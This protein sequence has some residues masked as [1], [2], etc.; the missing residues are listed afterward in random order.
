MRKAYVKTRLKVYSPLMSKLAGEG[1]EK[2][3][4]VK[5]RD[6]KNQR[7]E[8]VELDVVIDE[9]IGDVEN[10]KIISFHITKYFRHSN[11]RILTYTKI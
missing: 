6:M 11:Y 9:S 10:D 1:V 7:D 3:I 5:V 4:K 8:Y 2:M